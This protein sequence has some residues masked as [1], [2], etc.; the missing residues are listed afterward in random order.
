M[1]KFFLTALFAALFLAAGAD[2][3]SRWVDSVYNSLNDRERVAQLV[4]PHL[5]VADN[6]SGRA[7]VK[8]LVE[9]EKV[10]GILLGKN[11]VAGYA[12][13]NEYASGLADVPLMITADAEWGLAMRLP[14]A[15]RFPHNLALGAMADTAAMRAYG[16]ETARQLRQLGITV[17]FA[18][19]L[20]VNSNPLNPVIGFRSFGEDPGRVAALGAAYIRGLQQGGVMAVAKHFPGHGDTST[21]SHHTLPVVNRSRDDIES[22]DLVPFQ[23]AVEAGAGG[24]MTGHLFVPAL[25]K[26]GTPASLSRKITTDILRRQ[27]GFK[28]LIFTDALEMKGARAPDGVNNCVAALAAGAD[29][30]LGPA[31][32]VRDIDAVMEAIADGRLDK[33]SIAGKVRRVLAA[34]YDLGLNRRSPVRP[35]P[36]LKTAATEKVLERLASGAVTLVR[37]DGMLLPIEADAK[38]AVLTVGG[39]AA[40][41]VDEC[42]A[43]DPAVTLLSETDIRRA[44]DFDVVLAPVVSS[45]SGSAALLLQL[46]RV[47]AGKLV[48]VFFMNP[49]KVKAFAAALDNLPTLMLAGDDLPSLQRAAARALMGAAP[50]S[51]RVPVNVDGVMELGE[52]VDINSPVIVL[53][54]PEEPFHEPDIERMAH[55]IDSLVDRGLATGAFPGCQ[56]MVVKD[57]ETIYRTAA[58]FTDRTR[59]T[60]VTDNT[61]FDVASVTKVAATLP[62]LMKAYER[63]MFRLDDHLGIYIPETSCDSKGSLSIRQLLYHTSGLQPGMNARRFAFTEVVPEVDYEAGIVAED[64][65][66]HE[67]VTVEPEMQLRPDL[68]SEVPGDGFS[69]RFSVD[70]WLSEAARDSVVAH[71]VNNIPVSPVKR[72]R[73]SCL[74]FILLAEALQRMTGTSL[75]D[76]LDA[77]IY[78]P[79]GLRH[80]MFRPLD[81]GVDVSGIAATER[82]NVLGRGLV[83]GTVHDETAAVGGGE[84]GNAGLFSNASDLAA[85]CEMLLAGGIYK[86]QRIFR[87]DVV[88]TFMTSRSPAANRG[89]GWDI[90][91]SGRWIGHT[92]FTGT[93]VWLDYKRN[94]AV[95]VLTN[96]VCPSRDNAA[97]RR[98]NFREAILKAVAAEF[99]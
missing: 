7:S 43:Y 72:Y 2:E 11:N 87:E 80:I 8:A 88:E 97:F 17:S 86:G 4:I 27:I 20:D 78:R 12:S 61:I 33:T 18:P 73:Y 38:V 92:G 63:N 37:N 16:L 68:F 58:G 75:A 47:A 93:C 81:N 1:K 49:Y 69:I 34:K 53:G 50:V 52:G 79:M 40:A 13:L 98:L 62:G 45:K 35:S 91:G 25:D 29:I 82:D 66:M 55:R 56:V 96:R 51:G 32:P 42:R 44:V 48:P 31:S 99:I 71:I 41:F 26:S 22:I 30:L 15:P 19:D 64:E 36:V 83:H 14:D 94:I 85:F 89:L 67:I 70:H 95:V 76:W 60:K 84:L 46:R 28:G 59:R 77:E 90:T 9:G 24:I 74:N 3:R 54:E 65:D 6:A 57:G 39:A 21:D 10:G 23:A 5:V